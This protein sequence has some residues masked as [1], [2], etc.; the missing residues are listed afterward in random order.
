MFFWAF[1]FH[2]TF[3]P[4]SIDSCVSSAIVLDFR[5]QVDL[6]F[7]FYFQNIKNSR[8]SIQF[9]FL[10]SVWNPFF[11]FSHPFRFWLNVLFFQKDLL[12]KM[13]NSKVISTNLIPWSVLLKETAVQYPFQT[14]SLLRENENSFIN[15]DCLR[16]R[17]NG[18][19]VV[20]SGDVMLQNLFILLVKREAC[21]NHHIQSH[22]KAPNIDK[23][24]TVASSINQF[25]RSVGGGATESGKKLLF[26]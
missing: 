1:I 25:R 2:L 21:L 9:S 6:G 7:L 20:E 24:P 17:E 23:L 8:K 18:W 14:N 15:F 4:F 22:S 26:F 19:E 10:F 3:Q 11:C 5:K 12:F 13:L 16:W